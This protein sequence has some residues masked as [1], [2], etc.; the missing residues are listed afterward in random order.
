M[1]PEAVLATLRELWQVLERLGLPSALM[2][3]LAL[4][5][6]KHP[7][8]TRDVDILV[9]LGDTHV[10]TLMGHLIAAGFRAKR[11]DPI[12]RLA[13]AEFLQVL[14]EPAG[15]FLEVQADLLLAR[16][17]YQRHAVERR[18]PAAPAELGF[19]LRVLACEDLILHKLLAGRVIDLADAAAILRANRGAI[20]LTYLLRWVHEH[21]LDGDFAR[22]WQEACPSQPVP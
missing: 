2:G 14:Y 22:I 9:A 12:V 21:E 20:D 15:S 18:V 13:D 16:N 6:W 17:E 8:F 10:A 11:A 19:D 5:F 4:S 3:G 7:R 1:P